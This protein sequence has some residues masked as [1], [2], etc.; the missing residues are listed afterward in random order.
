MAAVVVSV[1]VAVVVAV[2]LPD[3]VTVDAPPDA[4]TVVV[5]SGGPMVLELAPGVEE[6]SLEYET[7]VDREDL[8]VVVVEVTE[9]ALLAWSEEELTNPQ[10]AR[11]EAAAATRSNVAKATG[12]LFNLATKC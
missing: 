5:D 1:T 3:T 4:V 8:E 2:A 12:N 7:A 6:L 10:P 11:R 9:A